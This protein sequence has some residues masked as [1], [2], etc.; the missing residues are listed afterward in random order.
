MF[1][2]ND[3]IINKKE[4]KGKGREGGKEGGRGKQKKK[5]V[6]GNISN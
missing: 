5:D 3:N 2:K 4:E 1:F 6:R